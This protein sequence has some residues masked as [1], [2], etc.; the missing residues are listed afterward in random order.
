VLLYPVITMTDPHA[1]DGSR[2]ALLG[3]RPPAALVARA[4]L[5]G[6]VSK[7]TPPVF[8]AHTAEDGTVPVENSILF[9]RALR[10]AGVPAEMHLYEKGAHG[11][12]WEAG[13]G[14][15]SAWPRRCEEWMQSHGWLPAPPA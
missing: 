6:A 3:D 13:L 2:R 15:T 10:A 1:H 8:L 5:E 14:P 4:S 7:T 9:Y 11:F 12:G